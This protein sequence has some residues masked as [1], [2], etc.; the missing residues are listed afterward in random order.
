MIEKKVEDR[1]AELTEKQKKINKHNQSIKEL[2]RI[3][4]IEKD[5]IALKNKIE[6]M[7]QEKKILLEKHGL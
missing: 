2:K 3:T 6:K 4:K 1:K 5:I 7:K